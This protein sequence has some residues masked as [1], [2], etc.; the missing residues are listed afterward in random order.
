MSLLCHLGHFHGQVVR[1]YLLVCSLKARLLVW[2]AVYF[3]ACLSPLQTIDGLNLWFVS[4][5]AEVGARS[6]K[7]KVATSLPWVFSSETSRY[8]PP[9]TAP[10]L[11]SK[12]RALEFVNQKNKKRPRPAGL[13]LEI[14]PSPAGLRDA[15]EI[16][17]FANKFLL[18][19]FPQG[20]G[21]RHL[22]MNDRALASPRVPASDVLS[23][24]TAGQLYFV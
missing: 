22:L 1:I 8:L 21:E 18:Q 19:I 20:G 12:D 7:D 23:T 2:S 3:G 6:G 4:R 5:Q 11:D 13:G 24:N 10:F 9:Q 15:S 14:S 16:W 17:D